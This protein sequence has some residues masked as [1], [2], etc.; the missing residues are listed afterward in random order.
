MKN[1]IDALNWRYATKRMTGQKVPLEIIARIIEA[2]HLSPSGIGLQPYEIIVISN[3]EIK[4]QILPIAMNQ[5][6]IV[7]SSHLLIFAAW[8]N[9]TTGRI[10][11]VFKHLNK[12][13]NQQEEV[14]KRQKDF[15]IEYFKKFTEE[16]NFHH[17]AKQ[18]HIGLG[19][20]IAAAALE[21]IDATPM[22]GFNPV[23][24]DELLG[25]KEKGL[26]SS[27]LLALG[28][29]DKINDY[30]LKLKKVRKPISEFLIEIK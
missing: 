8:D 13:R 15:A 28:Y 22:E 29:R 27:M 19:L 10:E 21:E 6:Q 5:P 20:S 9:Y 11:H 24:L 1:L 2:A 3:P 7:E 23:Q 17:A 18:A 30:N 25:L 26:R 12:E 4:N 14:T 16:E